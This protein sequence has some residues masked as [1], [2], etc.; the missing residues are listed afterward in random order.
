[1][2]RE[3]QFRRETVCRGERLADLP[4]IPPCSVARLLS[5]L[6]EFFTEFLRD[7]RHCEVPI[8][9]FSAAIAVASHLR[10]VLTLYALY[11]NQTL[12]R[13]IERSGTIVATP[14][15]S[16]LHHRYARI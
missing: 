7:H 6:P 4:N 14:I 13:A 5:P 9:A 3:Q 1:M 16:G 15:L 10:R 2:V 12:R 11:Y 8:A